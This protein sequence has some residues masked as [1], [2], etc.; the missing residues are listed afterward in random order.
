MY[1]YNQYVE[2]ILICCGILIGCIVYDCF[3]HLY[4]ERKKKY[5]NR[6]IKETV[7]D[8]YN[9]QPCITTETTQV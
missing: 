3:Y 5:P 2:P 1:F 9:K 8:A 7:K 6:M 4:K